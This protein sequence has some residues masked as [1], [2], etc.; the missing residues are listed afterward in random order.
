M[1]D[2][3]AVLVPGVNT[4]WATQANPRGTGRKTDR[5]SN[6]HTPYAD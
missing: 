1:P 6:L 3:E 2:L 4:Q 5:N